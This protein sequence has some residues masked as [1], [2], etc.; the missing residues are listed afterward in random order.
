MTSSGTTW[1]VYLL[2]CR[3]GS[4]YT[5]ITNALS[6]RFAAHLQGKGARYTRSHPPERLVGSLP[7]ANRSEASIAEYQIKK[8]KPDQKLALFNTAKV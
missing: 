3:D 5:G 2:E 4:L 8:L 1:C 6:R 7:Y